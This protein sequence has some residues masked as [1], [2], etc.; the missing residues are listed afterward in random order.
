MTPLQLSSTPLHFWGVGWPG[1]QVCG[2]PP[3][4]FCT[5]I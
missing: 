5:V 1:T 2:T 3:T 4:Q